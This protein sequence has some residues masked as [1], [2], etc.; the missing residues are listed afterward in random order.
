VP[1]RHN[2]PNNQTPPQNKKTRFEEGEAFIQRGKILGGERKKWKK[3]KKAKTKNQR[4]SSSIRQRGNV[5]K[6]RRKVKWFKKGRVSTKGKCIHIREKGKKTQ[7]SSWE[8]RREWK[9]SRQKKGG[10]RK[11]FGVFN[12]KDTDEA[13]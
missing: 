6:E 11:P 9:R 1:Q 12:R 13:G 5:K 8:G 2:P 3:V 7:K 4:S 10:D